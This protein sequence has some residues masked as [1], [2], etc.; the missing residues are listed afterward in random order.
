MFKKILFLIPFIFLILLHF[1]GLASAERINNPTEIYIIGTVHIS[2]PNYNSDTLL[3]I[4]NY[5]NP[6][7]ILIECDTSFM[8]PDFE[9]KDDIK[10]TFME[11]NAVTEYKKNKSVQLRAIDIP[12]GD[13]FFDDPVRK[14]NESNF[15]YDILY[16]S[17]SENENLNEEAIYF[18][19]R[20]ADMMN[21]ADKMVNAKASYINSPEGSTNADTINYYTYSG[22]SRLIDLIPELSQYKTYW[23][24]EYSNWNKRN[25]VM[26]ENI[27][28][29]KKYFNGKKIVV[30]CGFAHMN[31]LKAGILEN[32]D[33][34]LKEF[35]DY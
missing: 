30:L 33:L 23:D 22:L 14:I 32:S 21:T 25:N 3:N 6:D 27:L 8:T 20:I 9:L 2:T 1:A 24:N 18:L 4:L 28:K 26:L 10:Y 15:F 5:I 29:H 17:K 13:S 31:F 35:W 12:G 11:T 16:L 34:I 19:D 7:V